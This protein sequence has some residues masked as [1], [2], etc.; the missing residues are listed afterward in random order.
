MGIMHYVALAITAFFMAAGC[1][2]ASAANDTS[3]KILQRWSGAQDGRESFAT[4]VVDDAKGWEQFWQEIGRDPP[5]AFDSSQMTALIVFLGQRRT[6]G[7]SVEIVEVLHSGEYL[8]VEYTEQTPGPDRRVTQVI[9][10]PWT[11]ILLPRI[12]TPVHFVRS[13][14]GIENR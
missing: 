1:W 2:S 11:V 8:R 12:S 5:Q 10:A 14:S 4:L 3:P 13:V 9:T 6:G 7:Y